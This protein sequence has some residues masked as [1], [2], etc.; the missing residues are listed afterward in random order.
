MNLTYYFPC[1]GFR[2]ERGFLRVSELK[3]DGVTA[4][5]DPWVSRGTHGRQFMKRMWNKFAWGL[6]IVLGLFFVAQGVSKLVG[7]T[8]VHW[9]SRFERWGYPNR[10]QWAVGVVEICSAVAL[11]A[12]HTRRLAAVS[13]TI[14]MAGATMTHVMHGET[15]RVIAPLI[16]GGMLLLLLRRP[17][18]KPDERADA[19]RG[20]PL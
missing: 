4:E 9:A 6:S 8:A 7:E 13:L 16:L 19:G 17:R 14:V 3:P 12:P 11:F 2:G 1:D 15:S 20:R 10:F 18:R 5:D